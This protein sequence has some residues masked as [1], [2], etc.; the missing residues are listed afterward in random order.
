MFSY[1]QAAAHQE[2][3]PMP[4]HTGIPTMVVQMRIGKRADHPR[5]FALALAF[6]LALAF[7]PW[8]RLG[9][10]ASAISLHTGAM[11]CRIKRRETA[12]INLW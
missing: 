3:P 11:L 10:C 9:R 2:T 5:A 8:T 1:M 7:T 4:P 12:G 6:V